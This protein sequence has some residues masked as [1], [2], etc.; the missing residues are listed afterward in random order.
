MRRK[1]GLSWKYFILNFMNVSILRNVTSACYQVK[2][3]GNYLCMELEN[4][5]SIYKNYRETPRVFDSQVSTA[6]NVC[7]AA[8]PKR[9]TKVYSPFIYPF[10]YFIPYYHQMFIHPSFLV[11][12]NTKVYNKQ[13]LLMVQYYHMIF[14]TTRRSCN[15]VQPQMDVEK[16]FEVSLC[17]H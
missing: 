16:T 4:Y 10:S 14:L 1:E 13:S 9:Q 15:I 3:K 12:G 5:K 8:R 7:K 11:G 2:Q 6:R 17:L